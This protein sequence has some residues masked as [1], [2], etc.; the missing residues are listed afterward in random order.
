M[1]TGDLSVSDET[2][3]W[4]AR[5]V[6]YLEGTWEQLKGLL[7]TFSKEEFRFQADG[8]ANPYMRSVVGRLDSE[9]SRR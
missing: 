8:P 1:N 9:Y 5:D 7:P 2:G 4:R 6:R 3:R